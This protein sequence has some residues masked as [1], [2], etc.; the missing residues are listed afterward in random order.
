[1]ALLMSGFLQI[2]FLLSSFGTWYTIEKLGRRVSFM[3]TAVGMAIIMA[4]LAAMVAINTKT[5]GIVATIMIFLYQSFY[6]WGFMG[7]I[8]V[9]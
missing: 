9:S 3:F 6:T 1:M 2:W 8:W 7:G 5:S 4:I